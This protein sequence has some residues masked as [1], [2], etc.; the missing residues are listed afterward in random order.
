MLRGKLNAHYFNSL[1]KRLKKEKQ[2]SE[3]VWNCWEF[4]WLVQSSGLLTVLYG[5][6][7]GINKLAFHK[8]DSQRWFPYEESKG[9]ITSTAYYTLRTFFQILVFQHPGKK[10]DWDLKKKKDRNFSPQIFSMAW[11]CL[12]EIYRNGYFIILASD[13][14]NLTTPIDYLPSSI[15]NSLL[16]LLGASLCPANM[17]SIGPNNL[18]NIRTGKHCLL[19]LTTT[20]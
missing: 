8:L 16:Q 19:W 15:Y 18:K 1:A 17:A 10:M 6:I 11:F 9:D 5:R 2:D 12:A 14:L 7:I 13:I 20:F 3:T 4:F